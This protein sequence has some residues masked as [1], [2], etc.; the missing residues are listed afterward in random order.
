MALGTN[1]PELGPQ[2]QE[3]GD[4]ESRQQG[5]GNSHGEEELPDGHLSSFCGTNGT[6]LPWWAFAHAAAR[7]SPSTMNRSL[8]SGQ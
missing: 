4:Q 3:G 5:G 1:A 8:P 7:S 2:K 6:T